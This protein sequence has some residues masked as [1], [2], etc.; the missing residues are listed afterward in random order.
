TPRLP[1]DDGATLLDAVAP[2]L[3]DA[4]VTFGNLEGPL[5]DGGTTKKCRPDSSACYAFRTPTRYARYLRDAGFDLL[6]TA[7]NHSSDFGEGCRRETEAALD[8]HDIA[9]SGPVGSVATVERQGAKIAMIAFHTSR[10]CN[11]V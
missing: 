2:W 7:N 5:C 3:A 1:P 10:A 11:Y 6:S 8:A 4:D 9:W